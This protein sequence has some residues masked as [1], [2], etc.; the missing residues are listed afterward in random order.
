MEHLKPFIGKIIEVKLSGKRVIGGILIEVGS[1]IIVLH[2]MNKFLY[3]PTSHIHSIN[4]TPSE[5]YTINMQDIKWS[6]QPKEDFSFRTSLINAQAV[7]IETSLGKDQYV[8]GYIKHV[9]DD[10]IVFYSP[11]YKMLFIPLQHIK[12]ISPLQLDKPPYE[13][14]QSLL[15][16]YFQKSND[17]SATFAEQLKKYINKIV[18]FDVYFHIQR[19]GKIASL[20]QEQVEIVTGTNEHLYLNLT[21]IK[22]IQVS[23]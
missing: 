10:Y 12:W 2:V 23:N 15:P 13:F 21:H 9:L 17:F 11:V 20:Y 19:I 1:D 3:V 8:H 5:D 4:L 6:E 22:S 7:F 14:N 18:V 16:D